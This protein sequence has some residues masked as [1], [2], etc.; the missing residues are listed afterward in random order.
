[1]FKKKRKKKKGEMFYL[2]T[3]ST[4]FI[5]GYM[6]KGHSDTKKG[7]LLL[8][9][10]RLLFMEYWLEQEIDQWF[11]MRDRSDNPLHHEWKLP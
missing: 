1:M 5:Y 2:M 9:L 7:N 6:I 8:P 11:T 4:H 3:H 10:R